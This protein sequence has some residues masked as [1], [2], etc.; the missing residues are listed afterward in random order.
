MPNLHSKHEII[1]GESWNGERRRVSGI[2]IAGYRCDDDFVD[3]VNEFVVKSDNESDDDEE[4]EDSSKE[5]SVLRLSF[6]SEKFCGVKEV[7]FIKE[8]F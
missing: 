7:R 6:V 2:E 4:W 8:V 5:C 3:S 1:F